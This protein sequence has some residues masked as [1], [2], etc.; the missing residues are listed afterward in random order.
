MLRYYNSVHIIELVWMALLNIQNPHKTDQVKLVD[1]DLKLMPNVI[2]ATNHLWHN[3]FYLLRLIIRSAL[4]HKTISA[5]KNLLV[6][7]NE[8]HCFDTVTYGSKYWIKKLS[9]QIS[10]KMTKSYIS[11]DNN[12][13]RL[14]LWLHILGDFQHFQSTTQHPDTTLHI[15]TRKL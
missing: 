14:I 11:K 8:I 15:Y 13:N 7:I 10:I 5:R 9:G 12:P 6:K 2:E 3:V 4:N 1:Y